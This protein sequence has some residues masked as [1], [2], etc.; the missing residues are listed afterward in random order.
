MNCFYIEITTQVDTDVA[1]AIISTE[2]I[3]N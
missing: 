2:Q 3:G 1:Y